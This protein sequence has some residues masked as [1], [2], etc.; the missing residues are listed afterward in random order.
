MYEE[1]QKYYLKIKV[2]T[3]KVSVFKKHL[4][5]FSFR[6]KKSNFIHF[7]SC[8]KSNLKPENQQ[9]LYRILYNFKNA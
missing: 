4:G 2:C 3:I 9:F 5:K 8:L 1:V 6:K 7:L